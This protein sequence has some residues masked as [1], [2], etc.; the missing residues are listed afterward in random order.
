MAA[1]LCRQLLLQGSFA[2]VQ[3]QILVV[4]EVALTAVLGEESV[5]R[6]VHGK[7]GDEHHHLL[8]FGKG[9]LHKVEGG[10]QRGAGGLLGLFARIG[11]RLELPA[12]QVEGFLRSGGAGAAQFALPLAQYGQDL[13]TGGQAVFG[14]QP[15]RALLLGLGIVIHELLVE[16]LAEPSGISSGRVARAFLVSRRRA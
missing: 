11:Q 10:F 13:Q 3:Q 1:L 9:L 15:R 2:V 5:G 16:Q 4:L 12:Q 6:R 14:E 7:L 8:T